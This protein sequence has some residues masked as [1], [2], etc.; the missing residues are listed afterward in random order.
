MRQTRTFSA[1]TVAT[2]SVTNRPR[3]PGIH[4]DSSSPEFSAVLAPWESGTCAGCNDP[5][6]DT[7]DIGSILK[8]LIGVLH[9][10][11]HPVFGEL[12]LGG[13]MRRRLPTRSHHEW[14]FAGLAPWPI[15]AAVDLQ[16][17]E[18][19]PGARCCRECGRRLLLLLLQSSTWVS[20]RVEHVSFRD[21]RS[22]VRR[23]TAEFYVPEQAPVFRGDDGQDY[24]LIPLSVMRR[25]T[26]VNFQIRDDEGRPVAMPSLRQNQAITES[27]LLACADATTTGHSGHSAESRE[28]IE[29][30]VHR[31]VSGTQQELV[32][33]YESLEKGYVPAVVR[34][35]AAQPGFK[36]I[37]DRMADG[38][39]LWVMIPAGGPRRR[40]LTF[41]CDEP[42]YLRYRESGHKKGDQKPG[43]EAHTYRLGRTLRPWRLTVLGSALGLTPTRIQFPVPGAENAAS[44]H[45]EIDAPKGVQIVEASLLAGPPGGKN[46][47]FDRVQGCFPT[48]D[49]HVI[50]VPNGSLSRA[51]IGLQVANRGWLLTSMFSCW[52]VF[53]FLLA[54]AIHRAALKLTGDLPVVIL[55]ALAAA[56]AGFVAQ[57]DAHGLAAQL[58]KWVRALALIAAGLPLVAMTFIAFEA[59]APTHVGPA[60]WSAVGVSAAIAL[61]LLTV[62]CRAWWHQRKTV[63]SPW[64]QDPK[65][66]TGERKP[67][68]FRLPPKRF[69]LAEEDYGFNKPAM[70][71][72][73]AEGW[74]KDFQ[75]NKESEQ[76]LVAGLRKPLNH[77]RYSANTRPFWRILRHSGP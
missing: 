74:H 58:L 18:R 61:L 72:N 35:L 33:A 26:L 34:K 45:F 27:L 71:V 63:R 21:D 70:R 9:V 38:F 37:L 55:I 43:R 76:E 25:K 40:V 28:Q 65:P 17:V 14:N 10:M 19:D 54:F 44:F 67:A 6:R 39:V 57:S 36:A 47:A 32:A 52:A 68:P 5:P 41:S 48:V 42:L 60:L 2:F 75:L 22:V 13:V 11:V 7:Q 66:D 31:V 23:V 4:A 3:G 16:E 53:G 20:R 30:F 64:E 1:S 77:V 62:C 29:D 69:D 24:T 50:E 51:Q 73:T 8:I 59:A 12:Q 56:V 15:P 49:L 46:P